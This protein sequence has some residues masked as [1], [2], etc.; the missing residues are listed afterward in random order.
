MGLGSIEDCVQEAAHCLVQ[1]LR[2]TNGWWPFISTILTDLSLFQ[3][4][5]WKYFM[6]K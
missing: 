6:G 4:G 3:S 2:K 5:P 1:E